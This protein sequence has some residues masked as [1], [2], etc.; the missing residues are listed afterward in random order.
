MKVSIVCPFYNEEA[1]IV[2]ATMRMIANLNSQIE[3][4]ELILV[5]DGSR[6]RSLEMLKAALGAGDKRVRV[7]SCPVNQGRG[8]AL[9]NGI[10]AAKGAIVITTEADCSWGDDIVRRLRDELISYPGTHF[11]IA[12]P[13]LPGGG[14]M[15]VPLRR[16]LLTAIGNRLIRMF[17]MS[18]VTMNTGMT[19]AYWRDVIQPLEV[20]EDG[21]EFHLEVLLKLINLGFRVREIPAVITWQEHKLAAPGTA[22]RVSSTRIF[23]TIGTHLRFLAIAKPTQYF[24]VL[25]I[26]SLVAGGFFLA[27]ATLNLIR[28]GPAVYLAIVGLFMMVFSLLFAGFSVFFVK[29]GETMREQWLAP[30]RTLGKSIPPSILP[31]TQ[32]FPE[33]QD[34]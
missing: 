24:A 3:D 27:W 18:K 7:I 33:A 8:R 29:L 17:F 26:G 13:H 6:D 23:K 22:K 15:N 21:K 34:R 19:R 2:A 20:W 25:A 1:I 16:R 12:S 9:K 10:D 32:V 28:G 5:N 30:Y 14:L 4:W 11:V 31:A